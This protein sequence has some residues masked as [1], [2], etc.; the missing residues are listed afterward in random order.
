MAASFEV[1]SLPTAAVLDDPRG[2]LEQS[3]QKAD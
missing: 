2:A 1:P 3:V